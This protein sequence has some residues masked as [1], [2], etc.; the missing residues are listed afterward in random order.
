MKKISLVLSILLLFSGFEITNEG[1]GLRLYVFDCGSIKFED[2][3]HFGFS[4]DQ[5]EVREMFVPCSLIEHDK[6]R[7]LWDSGLP[8]SVVGKGE[9][10]VR[11]GIEQS[12]KRSLIQQLNEMD[13]LACFKFRWLKVT[14]EF[15]YRV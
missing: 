2:I 13:I 5:T 14:L 7:L 1:S 11:P 10:T 12:Y 15:K 9:I 6:G 8:L 4:N 3:S